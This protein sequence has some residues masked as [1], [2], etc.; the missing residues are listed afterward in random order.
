MIVASK[1]EKLGYY[2]FILPAL[3]VFSVFIFWP[4]IHSFILSLFKYNLMT[5][6]K[7]EFVGIT[8]FITLIK[9]PVFPAAMLNTIVYTLVTV[10]LSMML[11]LGF[12]LIMNNNLRFRNFY[13]VCF[14]IPYVSSMVA[15]SIVFSLLFN[16]S[17]S[18]IMNRILVMLGMKPVGWLS[19]SKLA[20]PVIMLLSLWKDLGYTI[21]IYLGGLLAIPR[22]IY[23]AA[24]L[25][26]ISSWK[27]L[28]RITIPL[29]KPT[30]LFLLITKTIASF[31][32]FTP[33]QVLTDGGPGYA[34]TTLVTLL[35]QKGFKEY[36]M[37]LASAAA[38]LLFIILLILSI[39]QNGLE[40]ER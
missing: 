20:L 15:V 4:M 16:A 3:I 12:A 29:L 25:D 9:S 13:M 34:T 17:T 31:Q 37:G 24:S 28:T 38:V 26:P 32:V 7:P 39:I 21:I 33:V 18:G 40:K 6:N 2:L 5:I 23:E 8:N 30:T 14:Y 11:G 35:Y 36:K 22:E 1:K 27:K 19:D 10:P